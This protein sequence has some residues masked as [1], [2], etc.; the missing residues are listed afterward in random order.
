MTPPSLLRGFFECHVRKG[1]PSMALPLMAH[2]WAAE[3]LSNMTFEKAPEEEVEER[4]A[5]ERVTAQRLNERADGGSGF[6]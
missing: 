4:S 5:M 3:A 1:T 6:A 2:P